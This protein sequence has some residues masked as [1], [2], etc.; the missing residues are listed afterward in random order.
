MIDMRDVAV[1]VLAGD[2][3]SEERPM[4]AAQALA[5]GLD[6]PSLR[7]LAG[8]SRGEYR[9]AR[10]LLDQVVDELGLPELPDDDQAVW[11]VV[12]SYA[13]RLVSGAIAPV[14]GAHAIAAYAGSL[15]F[16]E[17]LATFAFLADLWEDNA[18]ERVQLEQDMVREAEAMLRAVGD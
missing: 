6:S 1:R 13:R 9:E 17:P 3:A 10:E 4:I 5:E 8:L 16:P 12:V 7:E 18:A 14:E 15:G 11:E 2:L